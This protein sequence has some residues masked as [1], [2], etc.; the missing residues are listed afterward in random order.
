MAY[1]D[2]A[3]CD[4]VN[5]GVEW[6]EATDTEKQRAIDT[7][8]LWINA[9]Y[10]CSN[11]DPV[12]DNIQRA[13]AL[14]ADKFIKGEFFTPETATISE[15]T[16]KAGSVETSKTFQGGQRSEDSFAEIKLLLGSVCSISSTAQFVV[17]RV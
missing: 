1:T 11:T 10:A 14:L 3:Y 8:E 6:V 2:I 13:N 17:V 15:K 16:V 12:D 9:E 4:T 5:L 7:G